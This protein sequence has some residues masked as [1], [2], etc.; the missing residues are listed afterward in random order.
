MEIE[1]PKCGINC[2]GEAPNKPWFFHCECECGY[3]FCYDDYRSEY[4][5]M[6][7]NVIKEYK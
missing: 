4:Y 7:G 6:N 3:N 5:D 2:E 1:C